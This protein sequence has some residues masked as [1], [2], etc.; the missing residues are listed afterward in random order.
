MAANSSPLRI[1][2]VGSGKI[3]STFAFQFARTGGHDV[4]VIARPDSPRLA[5]L[6]RDGGIVK[7]DGG[8]AAVRVLDVLDEETSYDLLIVTLL[9]RQADALLPSLRRSAAA[10]I[11]FMFN[12][13]HPERF[14]EAV[15]PDR[16]SFGMPFVQGLLDVDGRLKTVIGAGGQKTIMSAARWV[17]VFNA[18]G[19]PAALELDMPL[20]LR[21]HVPLCVACESVSIAGERRGGGASWAEA[22]VVAHGVQASFGLLKALGHPIHPKSKRRLDRLPTPALTAMFW[23]LSRVR[24]FRE[25]LAT[26][27]TEYGNLV[28][29][30]VAAAPRAT[31]GVDV[32]RIQA[33]KP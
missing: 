21:C 7:V 31:S 18:A 8:R 3:G 32:P 12:T 14:G 2:I 28:D 4:T 33:M 25:L 23:G 30:M 17:D 27:M 24:S 5:Q 26:G 22:R 15:G 6:R 29:D 13:F 16:C 19:L 20:W 11:Q 1:A 9:D 10:R